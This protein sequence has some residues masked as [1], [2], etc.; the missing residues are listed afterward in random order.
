MDATLV[1]ER[2]TDLSGAGYLAASIEPGLVEPYLRQLAEHVGADHADQLMRTKA[3]RDGVGEYHLTLVSPPE[4]T[5][6]RGVAPVGPCA[7]WLVGLGRQTSLR[8]ETYFI[9]VT[10]PAVQAF[11]RGLGLPASDLHITLGFWPND[12][13]DRPKDSSSLISSSAS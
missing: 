6:G 1:P 3:E 5:A 7:A 4:Y 13:Y 10:S 12:I 11:R 9:V 8:A 2:H